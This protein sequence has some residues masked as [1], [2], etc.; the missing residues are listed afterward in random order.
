MAI[1]D[2]IITEMSRV[3]YLKFHW[4]PDDIEDAVEQILRFV[5]P[6]TP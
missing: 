5:N 3:I 4:Q 1:S 6:W 2:A